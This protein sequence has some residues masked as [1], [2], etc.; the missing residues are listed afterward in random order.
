MSRVCKHV[1][2]LEKV[3]NQRPQVTE[4]WKNRERHG[5]IMHPSLY[6]KSIRRALVHRR[7]PLQPARKCRARSA[8][9]SRISRTSLIDHQNEG[10][11]SQQPRFFF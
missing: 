10:S 9:Q 3:H 1:E 7:N 4:I 5:W 2:V 6:A 11:S 8:R